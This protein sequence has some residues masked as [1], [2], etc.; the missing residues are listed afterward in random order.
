M[1]EFEDLVFR[2]RAAQNNYFKKRSK[3][4][5]VASKELESEVDHWLNNINNPKLDF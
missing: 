4:W 1:N 5:L 3:Y 2:M